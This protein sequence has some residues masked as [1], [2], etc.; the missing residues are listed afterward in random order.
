MKGN[1]KTLSRE[2]SGT[3][4]WGCCLI[5]SLMFPDW[6]LYRGA[7][8]YTGLIT[9]RLHGENKLDFHF[10][11]SLTAVNLVK[12][13]WMKS[14]SDQEKS[15]WIPNYKALYNNTLILD[16]FIRRYA[17]NS[18]PAKNH[19]IVL[20]LLNYEKFPIKNQRTIISGTW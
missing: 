19:K 15:F 16:L 20:E 12:Q 8:Q 17:I 4:L 3:D 13:D 10:N 6:I 9:S 1:K 11:A 14:K 7:Y 5:L 2:K 18:N